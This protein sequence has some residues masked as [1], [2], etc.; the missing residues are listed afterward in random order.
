MCVSYGKYI[1]KNKQRKDG[2]KLIIIPQ[3]LLFNDIIGLTLLPIIFLYNIATP[4]LGRPGKIQ[5]LELIPD[6]AVNK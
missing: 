5:S 1:N 2:V 3:I 6:I 4:P